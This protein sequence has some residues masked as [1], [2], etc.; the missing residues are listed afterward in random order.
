MHPEFFQ[1]G[2]QRYQIWQW[3]AQFWQTPLETP[4]EDPIYRAPIDTTFAIYNK[5]FF[6]FRESP[7]GDQGRRALHRPPFAMVYRKPCATQ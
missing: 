6:S 5:A 2:A 1:I 4:G 7:R 3:E